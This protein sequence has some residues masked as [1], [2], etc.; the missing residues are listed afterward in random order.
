LSLRVKVDCSTTCWIYSEPASSLTKANNFS[1]AGTL[2]ACRSAE[3]AWKAAARISQ[4]IGATAYEPSVGVGLTL[5]PLTVEVGADGTVIQFHRLEPI[6]G[7]ASVVLAG[8]VSTAYGTVGHVS[9]EEEQRRAAERLELAYQG[10]LQLARVRVLSAHRSEDAVKVQRIL[11][12]ELTPQSMGVIAEVLDA[13]RNHLGFASRNQWTRFNRS[14]N[15]PDV[16]G[17]QAR[18]GKTNQ[19]PPPVPMPIDEA[20]RFIR[21]AAMRWLA[22][23]AG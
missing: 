15:H 17:D 3:E 5:R 19:E 16:Y 22:E 23:V 9:E 8:C 13:Q 2:D 1:S 4:S 11:A 14:I 18:H 21:D 6:V 7:V 20:Q 10:R 12:G